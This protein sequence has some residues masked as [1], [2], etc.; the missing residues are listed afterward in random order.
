MRW[1]AARWGGIEK[2]DWLEGNKVCE[3]RVGKEMGLDIGK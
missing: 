1:E 2:Q 3:E